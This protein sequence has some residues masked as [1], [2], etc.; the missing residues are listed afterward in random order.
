MTGRT[1]ASAAIVVFWIATVGY[2]A[3]AFHVPA[4]PEVTAIQPESPDALA[5][6]V[7]E[8]L[9]QHFRVIKEVLV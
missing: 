9:K 4:P 1:L 6:Q 7:Y 2:H 3:R 5:R 8:I